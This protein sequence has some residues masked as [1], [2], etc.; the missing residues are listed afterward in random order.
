KHIVFDRCWD[1]SFSSHP[2]IIDNDQQTFE[3][4]IKTTYKRE[5][6]TNDFN[7]KINFLDKYHY[8]EFDEESKFFEHEINYLY[9]VEIEQIPKNNLEFSYDMQVIKINDLPKKLNQL[10]FAPWV[11][12]INFKKIMNFLL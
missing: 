8:K 9:L 4:A 11:K 6:F 7:L 2:L 1:L 10:D 12:K 5:W 3:E